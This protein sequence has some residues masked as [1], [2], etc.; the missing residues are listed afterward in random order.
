MQ[1]I[2]SKV[3]AFAKVVDDLY[4]T[5]VKKFPKPVANLESLHSTLD[6]V[7]AL[8]KDNPEDFESV[9]DAL[10]DLANCTVACIVELDEEQENKKRI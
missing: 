10:I 1:Q 8:V 3:V 5:Y 4:D 2:N 6:K 9:R 7:T